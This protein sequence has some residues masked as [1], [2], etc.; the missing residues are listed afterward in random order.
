VAD[1]DSNPDTPRVKDGEPLIL[2]FF[3]TT[4]EDRIQY[5][6]AIAADLAKVGIGTQLFQVP[7]PAV[8]F[9]SVTN[10]GIMATGDFDM[11]IYASSN[12]PTSPNYDQDG[13]TCSGIPSAENPSG[14]NFPRFCNADFDKLNDQIR[15]NLDPASRLD[16]K[17]QAIQ[18][19]NDAVAWNGL[20]QRVWWVAVAGDR[21]SAD[22]FKGTF[23]D[24]ASN[25]IEK[26][27]LW[28]PAS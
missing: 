23:G 21:F 26:P 18:I 17:H 22:S 1:D 4:R 2:K 19:L 8:L 14:G 15:S 5:Q 25:W 16:Q 3:T 27:E 12:D 20:Y 9:A 7:G 6:T 11:S 13:W 24:L 28:T 10:R